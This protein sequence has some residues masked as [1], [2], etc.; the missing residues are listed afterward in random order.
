MPTCTHVKYRHFHETNTGQPFHCL[1]YAGQHAA[2]FN[3]KKE[4]E[5]WKFNFLS[6]KSRLDRIEELV[7]L[8]FCQRKST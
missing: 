4:L 8:S 6:E 2:S 5:S 7:I 3:P 1:Q